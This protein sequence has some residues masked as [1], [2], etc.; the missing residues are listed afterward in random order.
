MAD[1]LLVAKKSNFN[2]ILIYGA[3]KIFFYYLA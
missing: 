1:T 3:I 2:K